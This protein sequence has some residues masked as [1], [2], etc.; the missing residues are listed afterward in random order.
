MPAKKSSPALWLVKSPDLQLSDSSFFSL[1]DSQRCVVLL[2]NGSSFCYM[3]TLRTMFG[4]NVGGVP[5]NS[6]F[7]NSVLIS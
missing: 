1:C 3:L 2:D 5:I 6:K 4:L 7:S